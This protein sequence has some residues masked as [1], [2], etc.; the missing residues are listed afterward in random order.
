M[1]LRRVQGS[2]NK[3]FG[4]SDS[5]VNERARLILYFAV[6]ASFAFVA[7]AIYY[8]AV[9]G[10]TVGTAA[11]VCAALMTATVPWVLVRTSSVLIAANILAGSV[12]VGLT[13]VA[14]VRGGFPSTVLVWLLTIP[15]FGN[16]V[17]NARVVTL[18]TLVCGL[19]I[20]FFFV[21]DYVGHAPD[22]LLPYDSS[23]HLFLS[24]V[25]LLA[26][27]A[28]LFVL[29]K[30]VG[31]ARRQMA[32]ER[33][34]LEETL[35][36]AQRVESIGAMAGGVAHDFGN[37][38]MVMQCSVEILKRHL[39]SPE[40]RKKDIEAL[41]G[42]IAR[43]TDLTKQMRMFARRELPKPQLISIRKTLMELSMLLE[44]S[45]GASVSMELDIAD[46]LPLVRI[47]SGQLDQVLLNMAF[48]AKDAMEG[49]G[50]LSITTLAVNL[51]HEMALKVGSQ[52]PGDY[53]EIRIGD[54][55][56]GI[57][58]DIVEKIF[59]PFFTTKE[60]GRGTGLGLATSQGIIRRAGGSISVRT[61][62]GSGTRFS[63]FLPAAQGQARGTNTH[64]IIKDESVGATVLL[65]E[66]EKA[67]RQYWRSLLVR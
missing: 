37:T 65:V 56:V 32:H 42:A 31:A 43:G 5:D 18:W 39:D 12:V 25:G 57:P 45:L 63:I 50:V 67:V 62:I 26:L 49:G 13:G 8:G 2:L 7:F 29:S 9:L 23:A 55:G 44:R 14:V 47:D 15:V 52:S 3:S 59:D 51:S 60:S 11:L 53:L 21:L 24:F 64:S 48:N 20:V 40:A 19:E 1:P 41:E 61:E 30:P 16:L 46:D 27:L 38:L 10:A 66:D 54:T 6:G 34:T 22:P 35:V 33:D 17:A 28:L 58:S 36:H 4:A